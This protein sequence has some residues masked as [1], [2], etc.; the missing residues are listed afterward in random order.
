MLGHW[1][2][3]LRLKCSSARSCENLWLRVYMGVSLCVE[4]AIQGVRRGDEDKTDTRSINNLFSF[5][6]WNRNWVT[7]IVFP[8]LF[9]DWPW[10]GGI[11]IWGEKLTIFSCQKVKSADIGQFCLLFSLL[12]FFLLFYFSLLFIF[13]FCLPPVFFFLWEWDDWMKCLGFEICLTRYDI[14]L[15]K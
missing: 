12:L 4:Q 7:F 3:Y 2:V 11:R 10:R 8:N 13:S 6:L 9:T 15:P 14:Q 5:A 1:L